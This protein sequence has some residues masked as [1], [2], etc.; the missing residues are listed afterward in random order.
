M[1]NP[2]AAVITNID[3]DHL[4]HYGSMEGLIIAFERFANQIPFYGVCAFNAH[5]SALRKIAENMTKPFVTFAQ[6]DLSI[7]PDLQEEDTINYHARNVAHSSTG[8]E[9][10]LYIDGTK[11]HHFKLNAP[12]RHNV[13]NALGAISV[14]VEL[15]HEPKSLVQ[16]LAK[17]DGVG[18]RFQKIFEEDNFEIID[19]YAHHPT[20]IFETIKTAKESRREKEV[21]VI[22]E[23]HRFTRTKS[24]WA[25]FLHC[26]NLA[27][28]VL[29]APIYP[30]NEAPIKG[31]N[32]E[33]LVSDINK[34]HPGLCESFEDWSR[35]ESFIQIKKKKKTILLALGA[36]AVGKRVKNIS[37]KFERDKNIIF[38]FN[39]DLTKYSTM[40]LEAYGDIVVVETIS[41]LGA[42]VKE[43]GR[44]NISYK[45]IGWGANFIIP[46]RPEFVLIKLNFPL[47]KSIF[48]QEVSEYWLPASFAL[49][50]L[51]SIASKRG[52]K[53]WEVFTG[54]PAS[55][56]GA[57]AMNAGTS[58][59]EIGDLVKE[60]KIL[61]KAGEVRH[62]KVDEHSFSYRKNHFLGEGEIIVEVLLAHKGIDRG[63]AEKIKT[64]LKM[65]TDSQP[66]K[67]K[68]CGC[69]FKNYIEVTA[70]QEMTCRAGLS[71]DI[72]G[73]KGISVNDLRISPKHANFMENRGLA[74]SS[75]VWE[76]VQ[77]TKRELKLQY[78]V[79][80]ETEV[81]FPK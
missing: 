33:S 5:D 81:H 69:M 44:E 60:V 63:V 8:A 46:K 13:L 78:G 35:V 62:Y 75:D 54:I 36:G 32:S 79:E 55:L 12:G 58:L 21:C 56:G 53:G 37:K 43:L 19:D 42:L 68:T 15:G 51:T 41:S 11:S 31:I 18:R 40:K 48:D 47:D 61:S 25:D 10:D 4:D 16:A 49:N 64:Y 50:V 59:G 72:M 23:P 39:K 30:A 77:F 73:L 14:A 76:L 26:F 7:D 6:G 17:Y 1:L 66:L 2:V 67:E 70:S 71:I 3:A 52:F 80:F 38:E 34:L 74:A 29:I 57:L 27:D 28:K 20:E 45:V 22:F 9:F 24:C 65:R